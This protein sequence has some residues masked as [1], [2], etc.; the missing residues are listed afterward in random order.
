MHI[1]RAANGDHESLI[2]DIL[3][4]DELQRI[5]NRLKGRKRQ[6][7]DLIFLK[8]YAD[9]EV[10]TKLSVSRQYVHR[11]KKELVGM[12]KEEVLDIN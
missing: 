8:D 7:F 12:I 3:I 4:T 5:R 2:H 6:I 1:R 10:A 11:I 9:L